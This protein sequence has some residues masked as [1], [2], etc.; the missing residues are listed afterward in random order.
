MLIYLGY[1]CIYHKGFYTVLFI[2]NNQNAVMLLHSANQ[3]HAVLVRT[4]KKL[5]RH[6]KIPKHKFSLGL[7]H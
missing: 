4:K 6:K 7:L 5:K 3:E 2:V 1:T